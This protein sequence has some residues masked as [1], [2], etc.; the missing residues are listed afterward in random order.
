[1]SG[2]R[3][4]GTCPRCYGEG[5]LE[6]VDGRELCAV[7]ARRARKRTGQQLRLDA[8]TT[9]RAAANRSYRTLPGARS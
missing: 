6:L 2:Q 3:K 4:I 1:M 9:R 8:D 7:C 5:R